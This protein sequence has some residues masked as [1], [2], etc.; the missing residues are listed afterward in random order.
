MAEEQIDNPDRNA[1]A[2]AN[3]DAIYR[4]ISGANPADLAEQVRVMGGTRAAAQAAGVTQRTVQRWI[5]T[6]GTQR[7]RNPGAA[8]RQALNTAFTQVRSTRQG[9][10]RIASGRRATLMRHNGAR[11][12]GTAKAGPVT[13]GGERA[14]I[15]S[16]TWN[17]HV[18][19][20][21]MDATY[22]AYID[23]GE[24]AAYHAF[25]DRFGDEY[26]QGGLFFDNFLFTDMTRLRFA[27]DIGAEE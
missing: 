6:T 11:M 23:G 27:P 18:G 17:H 19:A 8:A 25:N 26:G 1:Y 15:K 3:Q 5:T 21:I 16:R 2:R 10:E 22:K 13:P 9:R 12:R 14:Y 4:L 24:N 20:D 7:I